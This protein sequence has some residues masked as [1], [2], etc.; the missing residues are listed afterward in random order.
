MDPADE[1]ER[2]I[3]IGKRN[4]TV[5]QRAKA[6][7]RNIRCERGMRGT[8][9]IEEETGLPISGGTFACEFA[10]RGAKA[11]G[12]NLEPI[13]LDFY[14]SNC[15]DC[16]HRE[17]TGDLDHLGRWADEIIRERA[18]LQEERERRE[19]R[20]RILRAERA[21]KRRLSLGTLDAERQ[22]I[23]E[24][25]ERVDAAEVDFSAGEALVEQATLHPDAFP[26]ELLECL[27]VDGKDHGID[28]FLAAVYVVQERRGT[29]RLEDVVDLALWGLSNGVA[30]SASADY[31]SKSARTGDL[32]NNSGAFLNAIRLAG[33]RSYEL[34]GE[35][36]EPEPDVFVRFLSVDPDVSLSLLC[37]E[38]VQADAWRRASSAKAAVYALHSFPEHTERI[39]SALL[40]S[41]KYDDVYRYSGDPNPTESACKAI[42]TALLSE[43]AAV[44]AL[45][46]QTWTNATT[47]YRERLLNIY[48]AAVFPRGN[49]LPEGVVSAAAKRCT[50]VILEKSDGSLLE[51]ASNLLSLMCRSQRETIITLEQLFGCLAVI[52]QEIET[53]QP[54]PEDVEAYLKQEMRKMELSSSA[55][56]I[57]E[58]IRQGEAV[59]PDG[60]WTQ[61]VEMWQ[62]APDDSILK[63]YVSGIVAAAQSARRYLPQALPILY[64]VAFGNSVSARA[65]SVEALGRIARQSRELP[66]EVAVA[67]TAALGDPHVHVAAAAASVIPC[68]LVAEYDV[69][70]LCKRLLDIAQ[71][72]AQYDMPRKAEDAIQSALSISSR[73]SRPEVY[74]AVKSIALKVINTFPVY[75]AA[76]SLVRLD[77]LSSSLRWVPAVLKALRPSDEP[78]EDL[79]RDNRD[80]LVMRLRDH[81]EQSAVNIKEIY[82]L[83][84]ELIPINRMR[85]WQ[86]ADLLSELGAVDQSAAIAEQIASDLPDTPENHARILYSQQIE[87]C[88]KLECAVD[89]GD[90]TT[91]NAA[92]DDWRVHYE[93]EKQYKEEIG[94]GDQQFFPFPT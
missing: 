32:D 11:Q 21:A 76:E 38:L 45:I 31:L 65:K 42:A 3:E 13:A 52:S 62:G 60:F 1:I 73:S 37:A 50:N 27:V 64:S 88:F 84:V 4:Q 34:F 53:A 75:E 80:R 16:E 55:Y 83:G 18:R 30:L 90:I 72:C 26:A 91:I 49:E 94:N 54:D 36:I 70:N 87:D 93:A 78:N 23:L 5:I 9:L 6:W 8:G 58:S 7:C 63:E 56:R 10:A 41:L 24:L 57:S 33:P 89:A 46:D 15:I 29:L 92:A 28:A 82:D 40:D 77:C 71:A 19:Q 43:T 79:A 59:D 74:E 44:E 66:E 67:I 12:M 86:I 35:I 68:F 14:C 20:D 17:P 39:I 48:R 61:V 69:A 81:P 2:V 22:S 25:L 47:P 85:A 51:K